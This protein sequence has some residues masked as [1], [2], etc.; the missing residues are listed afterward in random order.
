MIGLGSDKNIE[1]QNCRDII[2][3]FTEHYQR[4]LFQQDCHG[5][6]LPLAF[7]L[8]CSLLKKCQWIILP[9][10][11]TMNVHHV[12]WVGEIVSKCY[13]AKGFVGLLQMILQQLKCQVKN[14]F[15]PFNDCTWPFG[16]DDG[17]TQVFFLIWEWEHLGTLKKELPENVINTIYIPSAWT[18][19]TETTMPV[20]RAM[21]VNPCATILPLI[22]FC[23]K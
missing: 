10:P 3:I 1:N 5:I 2:Y 23:K 19:L 22:I 11:P 9:L 7:R 8:V 12:W 21:M 6:W 4:Q 15:C 18:F 17:G 13:L 14:N 16:S 20:S